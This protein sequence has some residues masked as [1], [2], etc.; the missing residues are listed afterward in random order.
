MSRGPLLYL[1]V[2]VL[3]ALGLFLLLVFLF[4][5]IQIGLITVAFSKLGLSTGQAFL[6]LLATLLGSGVNLPVHR[7]KRLVKVPTAPGPDVPT[8]HRHYRPFPPPWAGEELREQVIAVN[9]GGCLVP[10][11]L[12][13]YFLSQT[14]PSVGLALALA[15]VTLVCHQLARP[16]AG[17]GIAIPVFLPPLAAAASALL[18]APPGQSAHVAY[19]AGCLGTLLGADVLRLLRSGPADFPDA[20]VLS[21]GGA[22]TFDG[23]FLTGVIAVLLA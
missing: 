8:L 2:V 12:S 16:V 5:L 15:A 17:V 7:S 19:M 11:L 14:G 4:L 3:A 18:L 21:I 22:G 10:C 23:V 1:P 13:L 20:P 6:V 9:V